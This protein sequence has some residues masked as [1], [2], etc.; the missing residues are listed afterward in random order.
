M[1]AA[2]SPDRPSRGGRQRSIPVAL[3]RA[4]VERV[5]GGRHARYWQRDGDRADLDWARPRDE[6]M[7][8]RPVSTAGFAAGRRRRPFIFASVCMAASV[9]AAAIVVVPTAFAGS[10]A[11]WTLVPGARALENPDYDFRDEQIA[12]VVLRAERARKDL[13]PAQLIGC[14][15]VARS[16]ETTVCGYGQLDA[17]LHIAMIL[18]LPCRPLFPGLSGTDGLAAAALLRHLKERVR[19]LL[20]PGVSRAVRATLHR[21]CRVVAGGGG[22]AD[23]AAARPRPDR[24]GVALLH[25]RGNYRGP[26]AR[27]QRHGTGNGRVLERVARDRAG[28]HP[29]VHG[30][31]GSS[32]MRAHVRPVG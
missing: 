8:G 19:I 18:R 12:A 6:E 1:I 25:G 11:A 4:D 28:V 7:G 26:R 9:A 30:Q 29:V 15:Q 23:R 10:A 16:T 17:P 2:C 31:D 20:H 21:V 22:V 3:A 14:Y 13:P 5:S 32:G 27:R 24:A